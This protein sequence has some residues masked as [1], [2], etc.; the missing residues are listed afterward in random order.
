VGQGWCFI[1]F[2]SQHAGLGQIAEIALSHPSISL[3]LE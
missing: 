3:R 1:H 2:L